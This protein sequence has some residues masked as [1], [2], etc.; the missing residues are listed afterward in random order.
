MINYKPQVKL[1]YLNNPTSRILFLGYSQNETPLIKNL[2]EANCEVFHTKN[3]I[4]DTSGFDVVISYGYSHILSKKTINSSTAPIIN[5]HISYLP[6]NRGAH[7]NF[8]AH[9]DS[10]PSGV[11]IHMIDEGIDTGPIIFQKHVFFDQKKITFSD[12]Y[13]KLRFEIEKLFTDNIEDIV[14]KQFCLTPQIHLGT[15]HSIKDLPNNFSG[16]NTIIE[17]EISRLKK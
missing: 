5:L 7:P 9:Y 1:N 14:L 15:Y 6:W 3:Q 11:T 2:I 8:W 13:T 17:N 4:T 16:W 10:T 12:A